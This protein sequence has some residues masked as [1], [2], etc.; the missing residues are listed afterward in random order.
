MKIVCI[1]AGPA[2]L[3]FAILAKRFNHEH[4]ITVVER[5]PAGVT[6]GWGVVFW[7][8]L[9]GDLYRSD[10]ESARA[11]EA[12][13]VRWD[14][15][16][17]RIRGQR[18]VYVGGKAFSLGRDR[19]LEILTRRARELGITLQF[20][21]KVADLSEF[22]GAD[23][24]VACDGANSWVRQLHGEHFQTRIEPGRNKYIW[25]GT[26][27][28]FDAFTFAFEELPAGWIWFHAYRFNRET[29]TC[30]VEC[31][32]ETWEAL[33]FGTLG[34]EETL[35][36]LEDI[37]EEHLEG[38]PLLNQERG[39]RGMRWLNFK[40]ITNERWH[41]GQLVLMGDAA[42]T[43]HFSIGSGT[44]LAIQDAIGLARGLREHEEVPAAL[45]AY[46]EQRRMAL[47]PLQ[48]TARRSAEWFENVPLHARQDVAR[49][50][51]SLV[52]RRQELAWWRYLIYLANQEEALRGL[53][54][55]LHF[56]RG[57]VRSTAG[58]E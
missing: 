36:R 5:N 23:L 48:W 54:R 7:E 38:Q 56:A 1:G 8:A 26:R 29:S 57:W 58:W 17:I 53:L 21:R 10:E 24:I 22:A 52:N 40:R 18:A 47:L 19:L 4:E 31:P 6:Y 33:G 11:I 51:C 37:F 2:G 12:G 20:Q 35:R 3:Y 34:E 44:R 9:L 39:R 55:W 49:F 42:H 43:T 25:L 28:V 14:T 15:Q 30:I 46:E 50:A 32:L 45:Q 16:E 41:H 13:A 27:K